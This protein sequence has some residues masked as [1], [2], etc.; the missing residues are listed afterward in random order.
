MSLLKFRCDDCG[1]NIDKTNGIKYIFF[2]IKKD[3]I[4]ICKHCGC[5]YKIPTKTCFLISFCELIF[6]FI[7]FIVFIIFIVGISGI[8]DFFGIKSIVWKACLVP[9]SFIFTVCI[10]VAVL[11]IFTLMFSLKKVKE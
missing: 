8:Y 2:G 9:I 3:R 6:E 10:C 7:T 1:N 11:S 4:I 5:K